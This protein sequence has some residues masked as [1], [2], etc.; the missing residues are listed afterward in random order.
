MGPSDRYGTVG[1]PFAGR[2]GF[3]H[4]PDNDWRTI[5]PSSMMPLA[6]MRVFTRE[7]VRNSLNRVPIIFTG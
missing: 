7:K 4:F 2:Q 5:R 3:M 6:G 1:L